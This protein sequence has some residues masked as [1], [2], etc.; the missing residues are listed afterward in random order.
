MELMMQS[1]LADRF[2]LVVHTET[3]EGP[4][5]ALVLL[6]PGKT[7]PQIQPD[8]EPCPTEPASQASG[9]TPQ[10]PATD[11]TA[12]YPTVCGISRMQPSDPYDIR[13]GGKHVTIQVF[14]EIMPGPSA[15]GST[16]VDRPVLDR[17]GLTGTYDLSL[18][19][20][21]GPNPDRQS[22]PVGTGPPAVEAVA[23]QLGMK[24]EATRAPLDVLVVD[25][26]EEPAPN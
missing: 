5:Y 10:P 21:P 19:F 26:V 20:S 9:A 12:K 18:E 1:L 24:L 15:P 8:N 22:D 2:K 7:G 6:K 4:V 16:A 3:K 11:Y 13:Y 25:H 17:T 14:A 23:E